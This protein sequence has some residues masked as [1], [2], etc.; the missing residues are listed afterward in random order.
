MLIDVRQIQAFAL[1]WERHVGLFEK[2]CWPHPIHL[3]PTG[4]KSCYLLASYKHAL[5]RSGVRRFIKIS[6]VG[7]RVG[8]SKLRFDAASVSGIWLVVRRVAQMLRASGTSWAHEICEVRTYHSD[9]KCCLFHCG[10]SVNESVGK[11]Y[12]EVTNAKIHGM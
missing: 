3:T 1:L 8:G 11:L 4:V 5:L 2:T 9:H 10:G 6:S 7:H 12:E